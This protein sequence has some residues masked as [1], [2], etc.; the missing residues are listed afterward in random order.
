MTLQRISFAEA[1]QAKAAMSAERRRALYA[2]HDA[3]RNAAVHAA[4][5]KQREAH[6]LARLHRELGDEY[7]AATL[8][9]HRVHAGN[10]AAVA[11]A[12][13]VI[14]G[15]FVAGCAFFGTVGNGKTRL[16]ACIAHAA[17]QADLGVRFVTMQGL[18]DEVKDAFGDEGK[19]AAL[20]GFAHVPVLVVDDLGKEYGTEFAI[21]TRFD[22]WTARWNAKKPV[23]VTANCSPQDL[24]ALY[25]PPEKAGRVRVDASI[26][27][28]TVDR[29]V[30][31]SGGPKSWVRVVGKSERWTA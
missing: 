11:K 9:T 2:Q 31:L 18:L 27:E 10:R 22:F 5:R 13:E 19:A 21:T 24:L 14:A 17:I 3:E 4:L 16:A 12:R 7:D 6:R 15:G 20:H 23:I 25:G 30:A 29:I 1:V 8:E 28:G 26:G